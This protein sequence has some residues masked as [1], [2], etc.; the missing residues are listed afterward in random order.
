[1]VCAETTHKL[2]DLKIPLYVLLIEDGNGQ[3]QIAALGLLM[4]E[5]K[6]TFN[7]FFQKF[8]EH[9]P[10]SLKTRI[11]IT[12]KDMKERTVIQTLF[13]DSQ[14]IICLFHTLRTFNKDITCEKLGITS[15]QKDQIKKLFEQL[16]NCKNEQ[17]YQKL[18]TSLKNQTPH[19]VIEYFTNNWHKIRKQWVTG[20]TYSYGNFFNSTKNRLESFNSK[21]K[22]AVL[23]FSNVPEFFNQLFVIIKCVRSENDIN[24]INLIQKCPT[25]KPENIDEHK[26]FKLLTPYAFKFL[27][28]SLTSTNTEVLESTTLISCSCS[29]FNSLK[30]PCTHIFNKRQTNLCPIF[31]QQLCDKRWTRNYYFKSST[32]LKK[33]PRNDT[34]TDISIEL[35]STNT[36]ADEMFTKASIEGVKLAK[37]LSSCSQFNFER[38]MDQLKEII[39]LWSKNE[40]FVVQPLNLCQGSRRVDGMYFV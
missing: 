10:I 20:L 7:W 5:Q 19:Q 39:D 36:T 9:N 12:N 23:I 35:Q 3:N 32:I 26:Y 15:V 25:V 6:D 8:K 33:P 37:I 2:V 1:M 14:L 34:D 38:K 4:N 40:E 31:D 22:S 30:L 28:S 29:F 17:E 13:P 24:A 11:F 27:K 16:C 18:Y 21:L